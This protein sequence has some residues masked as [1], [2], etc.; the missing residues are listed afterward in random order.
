VRH[1]IL[2]DRHTPEHGGIV[3]SLIQL[4][5]QAPLFS[6]LHPDDLRGLAGKFSQVR[7]GR[8]DTIFREGERADCLFLID[9]GRI[10][11]FMRSARGE[12]H[13]IGVIGRGQIFGELSLLDRGTR[14]MNAKAMEASTVFGLESE[15]MWAMLD[16]RPALS[17]RLLELMARRLRRADQASQDL[18]FFDATTRLARRLLQLAEDHG[19]PVGEGDAVRITVQVTQREIAQMIGVKRGSANRLIASF[20]DRGWIEWNDGLPV[21]R[22]PEA[23]VRLAF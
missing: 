7:Y 1:L 3:A 22:E 13:L 15:V 10:K 21:I 9:D 2:T 8:G 19:K 18:V 14:A 5:E 4:L 6:V 17:R 11:L 12:E 23:L 20:A 16:D